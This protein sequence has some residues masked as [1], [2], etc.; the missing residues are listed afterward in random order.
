M[1]RSVDGNVCD[2]SYIKICDILFPKYVR[3]LV[4]L[5]LLIDPWP[6]FSAPKKPKV[7]DKIKFLPGVMLKIEDYQGNLERDRIKA[8]F[9]Q[10]GRVEAVDVREENPE[11]R[12]YVR[13]DN[14]ATT[15][16]V[17]QRLPGERVKFQYS[18]LK[19]M[20]PELLHLV[21]RDLH[22]S[23]DLARH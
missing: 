14:A 11:R 13:F 19:G 1:V 21:W 16:T 23:T 12:F 22:V 8:F 6:Y 5:S 20:R 2:F 18:V 17:M 15:N 4:Q 9:N 7:L 3:R 10:L